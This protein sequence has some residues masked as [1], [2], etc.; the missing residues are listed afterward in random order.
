VHRRAG[1][2]ISTSWATSL[3]DVALADSGVWGKRGPLPAINRRIYAPISC[4]SFRG[5][6]GEAEPTWAPEL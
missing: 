3:G 2:R 4:R 5:R 6:L 1:T